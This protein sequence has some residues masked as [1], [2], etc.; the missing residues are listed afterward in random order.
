MKKI[1]HENVMKLKEVIKVE[2]TLYLVFEY[3]DMN[4]FQYYQEV[5]DKGQIFTEDQ[6]RE[7]IYQSL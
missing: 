7:V 2:E 4:L 6:I 1:V 3:C 5:K